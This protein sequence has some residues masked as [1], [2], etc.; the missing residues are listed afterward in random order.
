MVPQ[1]TQHSEPVAT[2]NASVASPMYTNGETSAPRHLV[3]GD[4]NQSTTPFTTAQKPPRFCRVDTIHLKQKLW[5][6]LDKS[7]TA[8]EKTQAKQYWQYL[9]QFVR[10]KLRQEE[11]VELVSSILDTPSKGELSLSA[12]TRQNP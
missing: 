5:E 8:G 12:Q 10:G 4:A 7:D 11:F 9:G 2:P 3:N 1:Q 6:A